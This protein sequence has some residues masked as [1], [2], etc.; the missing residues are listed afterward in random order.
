MTQGNKSGPVTFG[1]FTV[2]VAA[3]DVRKHGVRLKVGGQ[4]LEILRML[5]ERPG[6]VVTRE[7]LRAALWAGDTFVDFDHSLNAAVN[8]LREALGDSAENPRYVETLPRRGYRFI[9]QINGQASAGASREEREGAPAVQ[10]QGWGMVSAMLTAV[11]L[12]VAAVGFDVGG[13]RGRLFGRAPAT[14]AVQS[15]AVLPFANLSNDPEQEY[16][17]DGMTEELITQLAQVRAL[18]VISR[19]SAM[20]YKQTKKSLPEIAR[21]LGVQAVVEGSVM[22]ADGRV[23]ITAQLVDAAS[24]A[25]QWAG[26]YERDLADVIGLQ[27]EVARAIATQVRATVTPRELAALAR[28]AAVNPEAYSLYLKARHLQNQELRQTTNQ[29]IELFEQAIAKDASF[30][31]S[32]T[33][34]A[35]ALVFSYPPRETMPRAKAAAERALEL[36]P[37]LPES[38]VASGLVQMFWEWDWTG[39]ER[40]FR[41]AIELDSHHSAA[42][43]RYAVLLATQGRFEEAVAIS[44]K[45]LEL[46][47][48]S[49]GIGHMLGRI[50][51]FAER[52]EEAIEQ[53]QRTLEIE[54]QDYWSTLFLGIVYGRLGRHNES[55]QQT[56]RAHVLA[57]APPEIVAKLGAVYREQ[58][59]R[60]TLRAMA[61]AEVARS[62]RG[63]VI[64]ST[65]AL[66]YAEL[67]EK[68]KAL[69]WLER[70]F[71]SHT[72]D[73]VYI[74]VEPHYESLRKEPRFQALLAKMKFPPKR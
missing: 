16:F 15:V 63:D 6:E 72:R 2:D 59:R 7:E 57:G 35:E 27:R 41:R 14:G 44:R 66:L 71:A 12:I 29:A 74:N 73:L 25:H 32:Y 51:Y 61:E 34:L 38:H 65:A 5:L 49:P 56:Q 52:N 31:L 19:T 23:R 55:Q 21:E 67:G 36:A 39:A 43:R 60:G 24:D 1:A 70:A 4:P 46:D 68:E 64:S 3:G 10:P 30:A 47:P 62:Q 26:T 54:P 33:G 45:A 50:H 18:R 48:F 8:K 20:R 28:P 17:A 22:R 37:E 9:G 11:L 42:Y 69:E 13:I 58:G 53:Y 40:A